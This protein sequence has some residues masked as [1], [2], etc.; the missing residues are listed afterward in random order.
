MLMGTRKKTFSKI[1]SPEK[2]GDFIS[3][4]NIYLPARSVK[5]KPRLVFAHAREIYFDFLFLLVDK[6]KCWRLR[7]FSNLQHGVR[8]CLF[9]EKKTFF[10]VWTKALRMMTT[11]TTIIHLSP[12]F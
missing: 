9:V 6:S 8:Q 3:N 10:H 4:E 5:T 12:Y 11:A 1:K 2:F 7:S